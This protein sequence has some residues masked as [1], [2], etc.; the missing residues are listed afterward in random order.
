M[1]GRA[2][3]ELLTTDEA[4]ALIA[5][6]CVLHIA[7]D[8]QA[9]R[10]LKR[11]NWIGG[12]T[13]YMLTHDGG[14]VERDKVFVTELPVPPDAASTEFVDIGHIPAISVDAPRFGFTLVIMPAMSEVHS[15]YSLTSAN[16]PG[17][18]DIPLMGW[19]SGVHADQRDKAKAKVFDGVTGEVADDRIV[20]MRAR[21]PFSKEAKVDIVN[22]VMP[23]TGDTFVFDAPSFSVRECEINGKRED[24]YEY[25]VRN[26]IGVH[27][28]LV[29]EMNGEPI[30]VSLRGVDAET[31]S[32]QF[33]APVMRGR[34]YRL[35]DAVTG[36]RDRL[37]RTIKER[38][39]HPVLAFNCFHNYA[40]GGLMA[41]SPYP[42]P[43]PVV[44]GELAH[45][46]MN[47]T[48][49]CLSIRNK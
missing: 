10:R 24:L 26:R 12:T 14:M 37:I 4:N 2:L 40:F 27:Q 35:G 48:L 21:L 47:Q 44:F 5:R 9:M 41:P 33:F 45:V 20:V 42:L 15:I 28:P 13:P 36:Y 34:V 32:V 43:G 46:L 8:E 38:A 22:L 1:G 49:V 16:I 18:R 31:R 30:C 23:G 25:A 19:V 7:G 29:T 39:L 17:I 6:G 11:G 3:N